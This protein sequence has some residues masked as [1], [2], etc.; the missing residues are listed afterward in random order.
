MSLWQLGEIQE[1]S[2]L[3][4]VSLAE[5]FSLRGINKQLEWFGWWK[6][7]KRDTHN[8][9]TEVADG[10]L[11]VPKTKRNIC[12]FSNSSA[13][14]SPKYCG[15]WQFVCSWQLVNLFAKNCLH[16]PR[17]SDYGNKQPRGRIKNSSSKDV[18]IVDLVRHFI[19]YL[20]SQL[21]INWHV[22]SGA[23]GLCGWRT[24]ETQLVTLD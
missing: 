17:R 12:E 8:R 16:S 6:D 15:D 19:S 20:I 21:S 11:I 1:T 5:H 10:W 3:K 22:S 18:D 24:R 4:A 13:S 9:E 7:I 2:R 14:L 23:R